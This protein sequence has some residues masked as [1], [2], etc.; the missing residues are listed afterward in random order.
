VVA[1]VV[2]SAEVVAWAALSKEEEEE[3]EEEEG[4]E[5]DTRDSTEAGTTSNAADEADT[6]DDAPGGH[7]ICNNR[8]SFPTT[9]RRL[10]ESKPTDSKRTTMSPRPPI[11]A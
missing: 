10:L 4:L 11:R 7:A 6:Q 3:E 8:N 5:V 2:A 1:E 9:S